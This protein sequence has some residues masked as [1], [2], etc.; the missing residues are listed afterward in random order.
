MEKEPVKD[1]VPRSMST[2]CQLVTEELVFQETLTQFLLEQPDFYVI[3]CVGLPGVGKSTLMRQLSGCPTSFSLLTRDKITNAEPGTLGI[4]AFVTSDRVVWIDCQPLMSAGVAERDIARS[5]ETYKENLGSEALTL[6]ATTEVL[7]LHTLAFIYC[8]AD[9][10]LVVQDHFPNPHL[11]RLLQT[12]EML[13]PNLSVD[14][15]TVDHLPNLVFIHQGKQHMSTKSMN[16]FYH[17]CFQTSRL[18]YKSKLNQFVGKPAD[19]QTNL[20]ILPD[21]SFA[22]KQIIDQLRCGLLALPKLT[23]NP[24]ALSEKTWLMFAHK[25]WE[26]VRKSALINEYSRLLP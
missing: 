18:R 1:Q 23:L 21:D 6:S 15:S 12:A 9:V 20:V 22:F 2:S 26:T 4:E 24:L 7:A 10:V 17:R 14:E 13:K 5:R 3:A 16:E 25:A 8:V 11:I 19:G